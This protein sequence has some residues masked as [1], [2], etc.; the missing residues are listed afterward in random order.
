M[1]LHALHIL[2]L[3]FLNSHIPVC[4]AG[5]GRGNVW[6]YEKRQCCDQKK[7]K[8]NTG[9]E[10]NKETMGVQRYWLL[11]LLFNCHELITGEGT[12][13]LLCVCVYLTALHS[14]GAWLVVVV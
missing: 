11:L 14:T 2:T 7:R 5:E 13:R 9:Q 1:P 6:Q 12:W 3:G 4:E 10:N 8:K